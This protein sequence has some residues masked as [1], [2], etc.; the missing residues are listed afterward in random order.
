MTGTGDKFV[1][2]IAASGPAGIQGPAGPDGPAGPQGAPGPAGTTGQ[3]AV[4]VVQ[5][6]HIDAPGDNNYR[7]LLT[8]SI[9]VTTVPAD[10]VMSIS[11][12]SG[13]TAYNGNSRCFSAYIWGTG[14][15]FDQQ[16][17]ITDL[18][19]TSGT[20]SMPIVAPGTYTVN[21]LGAS[22]CDLLYVKGSI[23]LMV[24]NR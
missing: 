1:A 16:E 5:Q 22:N 18:R 11:Q 17:V 2:T 9:D 19:V 21:L 23:T 15:L 10:L 7:I 3:R 6:G 24:L 20:S 13:V 14:T 8:A 4:T 12:T